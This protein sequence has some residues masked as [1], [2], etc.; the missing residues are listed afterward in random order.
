MTLEYTALD[1]KSDSSIYLEGLKGL[2]KDVTVNLTGNWYD[3][4]DL[5]ECG[6]LLV[7]TINSIDNLLRTLLENKLD[8]RQTLNSLVLVYNKNSKEVGDFEDLCE[9]VLGDY[10]IEPKELFKYCLDI[11][12]IK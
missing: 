8:F 9:R 12:L 4:G 3:V 11:G 10:G 5:F 7:W 1:F 6:E 2:V